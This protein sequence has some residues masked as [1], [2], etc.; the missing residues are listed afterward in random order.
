MNII[1]RTNKT[2][3]YVLGATMISAAPSVLA[4]VPRSLSPLLE[5]RVEIASSLAAQAA[6]C[7]AK[8]DTYHP[9]FRGCLDWH[10]AVHGVWTLVAY[11]KATEDRRYSGLIESILAPGKLKR[12][13]QYL[14]KHPAFEMPYGR[15]WFLRLAIDYNA[16]TGHAEMQA[17]ADEVAASLRDYFRESGVD[18]LSGSYGSASWGLLNLLDYA[19]YR[20]FSR[21]QS[22]VEAWIKTEYVSAELKCPYLPERGQFMAVCTNW[23]AL[24]SRILEP[25]EYMEWLNRFL[26]K[27]GLP[28]PVSRPVTA[29]HYGLNFS[30]A[31][32]L[33][34]MYGKTGR[35]DLAD[36]YAAHFANGFSPQSNWRGDYRK[37]GHWV[38][39]FGM[40]ALQPLFGPENGR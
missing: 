8:Q 7:S 21:L 28:D 16:G 32:G 3:L 19:R 26:E 31:W 36:A 2:L 34:D 25:A 13:R 27:N 30:R 15:A 23:A 5:K 10:S 12:E 6:F 39:Q 4:Q 24:V 22:E 38:A 29:H 33:W 17:M 20:Q 14:Q 40:Y 1:R 9:A 18:P 11:Q 37:V 35:L